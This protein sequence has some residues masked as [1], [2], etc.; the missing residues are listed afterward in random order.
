MPTISYRN[1]VE[2]AVAVPRGILHVGAPYNTCTFTPEAAVNHGLLLISCAFQQC[3]HGADATDALI[4]TGKIHIQAHKSE[5]VN[6]TDTL[7]VT[8][9][10]THCERTRRDTARGVHW[11]GHTIRGDPLACWGSLPPKNTTTPAPDTR[12]PP[13]TPTNV[14]GEQSDPCVNTRNA[15]VSNNRVYAAQFQR[16]QFSV[17]QH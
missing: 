4:I 3:Y 17:I 15:G 1:A 12:A 16:S 10:A 9:T 6:A 11:F 7:A 5:F 13:R 2:F 8:H 14:H